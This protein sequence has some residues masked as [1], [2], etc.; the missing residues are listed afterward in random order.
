MVVAVDLGL[1]KTQGNEP[2]ILEVAKM[3]IN[4]D[5]YTPETVLQKFAPKLARRT[6]VRRVANAKS[7]GEGWNGRAFDIGG[8]RVLKITSDE[9]EAKTSNHIKE[10]NLKHVVRV[11][12]VFEIPTNGERWFG[13]IQEKLSPLSNNEE[14]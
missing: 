4:E 8:G 1:S 9:I 10:K 7:L 14:A 3:K 5:Q 12:D 11:F 6:K 13:I 2:P